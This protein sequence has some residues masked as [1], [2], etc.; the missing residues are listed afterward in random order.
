MSATNITLTHFTQQNL[1]RSRI[2]WAQFVKHLDEDKINIAI[3]QE[4]YT[5]NYKIPTSVQ[6]QVFAYSNHNED[7][8]EQNRP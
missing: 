4:P 6:Y 7:P 1:G 5:L 2:A 3:I 8:T